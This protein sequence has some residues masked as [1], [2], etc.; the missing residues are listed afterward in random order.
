MHRRFQFSLRAL[1]VVMLASATFFGGIQF[2]RERRRREDFVH[3]V[4]TV[5]VRITSAVPFRDRIGERLASAV[6]RRIEQTTPYKVVAQNTG[7]D[8]ELS[9]TVANKRRSPY[10][11]EDGVTSVAI[12]WVDKHGSLLQPPVALPLNDSLDERTIQSLTAEIV[13]P[14]EAPW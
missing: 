5:R 2:E 14:M 8:S 10:L 13:G 12:K 7:C 3:G 11:N 9:I 1:L 4:R 6:E